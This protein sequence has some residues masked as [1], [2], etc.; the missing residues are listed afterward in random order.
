ME[1]FKIIADSASDLLSLEKT[2]FAVAPLKIITAEREFEDNENLCVEEMVTFLASYKGKSSSSCP[3][4]EDWLSAFGE[5]ENVF[6]VAITGT[7]SG[8]CSAALV[9][10]DMYES[11]CPGRR[12]FVINSLSA[13]PEISLIIERLSVLILGGKEYEEICE[14][15]TEYTKR[16][17]L[18]FVLES[19]R[20]LA[21]NGR[22]SPIAAK[23]AGILGIRVVGCASEKGDLQP[24]DKVRGEERALDTL[25]RRMKEEGYNGG[26]VNIAHCLNEG[27]AR[28]L[29]K[30]IS[31]SFPRA[32]IKVYQCRGLCSFYA[33]RGGV[34]VGY[35]KE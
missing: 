19:M 15:I 22:V 11:A 20:N 3:N 25:L 5:A 12:V 21:N 29:E 16:T 17:G 8:S 32:K 35:E 27:A 6:C 14:E 7:L 31:E 13:G 33:E 4:P 2:P 10:K 26:K 30:K 1:K 18:L 23:A 9:A 34:L 28:T 24:L